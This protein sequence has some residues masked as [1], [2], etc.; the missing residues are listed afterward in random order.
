VKAGEDVGQGDA[1]QPLSE[2][3]SDFDTSAANSAKASPVAQP[4]CHGMS[5]TLVRVL[6]SVG[7][8]GG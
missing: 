4:V 8:L 3:P 7:E 2:R 1:R 6:S 5:L